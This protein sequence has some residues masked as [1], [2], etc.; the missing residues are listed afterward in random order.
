SA[1]AFG[2]HGPDMSRVMSETLPLLVGRGAPSAF[3]SPGVGNASR[4]GAVLRRGSL[5]LVAALAIAPAASLFA[6]T[7]GAQTHGAPAAAS[8]PVAPVA[9]LYA[10]LGQLERS[11][12]TSFAARTQM[13]TPAVDRAFDLPTV[14]ATSVGLRYRSLPEA[15]KQQLLDQFRQFTVARYVSNFA[16]GNGDQLSVEPNARPSPIPGQQIVT[17]HIVNSDGGKTKVDYVMRQG[18]AGWQVVDVLLNGNISQVAVQ[19]ADFSSSFSSG[20]ATPLINSLRKKTQDFS[21][22]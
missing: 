14:L 22:G 17:S 20:D 11:Q 6:T 18:P 9:A 10:A 8:G 2:R 5:W 16:P 12:N 13:L 3:L 19:R 15:Q 7:A 21:D 1:L 4:P